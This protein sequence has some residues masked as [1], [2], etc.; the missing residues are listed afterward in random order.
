MKRARLLLAIGMAVTVTP[1][2]RAGDEDDTLAAEVAKLRGLKVKKKI[3]Q[4]VIGADDLRA[5]LTARFGEAYSAEELAGQQLSLERWGL[6]DAG[7]NV[8]DLLVDILTEQVAGFYDR[9]DATL[10]LAE[11]GADDAPAD[12]LLAHE[13]VHALQD[14]HFGLA[15]LTDLPHADADALLARHALI[16]GDGVVTSYEL[17]LAREGI[18]PPWGMDDAVTM[19]T[20]TIESASGHDRLD[21]A[22]LVVRDLLLFPYARGMR[23]V[24]ALRAR[25]PWKKVDAAFKKPPASTEQILHPELYLAGE[26]PDRVA[27]A[28]PAA[29]SGWRTRHETVWGEAGWSVLLREHGVAGE[30][31]ETAAAGWGGDRMVVY[32]H[33]ARDRADAAVG[34]GLTSWDAD[35]DA[36]E[37]EEAVIDAI[38]ALVTGTVLEHGRGRTV[39]LGV[40]LRVA[41]VERVEDRVLVIVGA[42]LALEATLAAEVWTSWKVSRAGG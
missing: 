42:P 1:P 32:T 14:Q 41:I 28:T 9:A 34:I 33:P 15:R 29:L 12:L 13:I 16:E 31:A 2:V 25:Q 22:P 5:R 17:M 23:F 20:K 30:R 26:Q 3:R 40:D 11:R 8:H 6:V 24:A 37:F 35:I 21:Q 38:D 27:A 19:M 39:W 7:V 36:M 18:A 4:G 10:Y